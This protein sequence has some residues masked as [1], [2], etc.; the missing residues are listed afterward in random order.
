MEICRMKLYK[1]DGLKSLV[2]IGMAYCDGDI[3]CVIEAKR[4]D[5]SM[6]QVFYSIKKIIVLSLFYDCIN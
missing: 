4:M 5:Q 1:S 2:V 3:L 6:K